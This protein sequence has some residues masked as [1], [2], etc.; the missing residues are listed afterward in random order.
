MRRELIAA[1]TFALASRI[2]AATARRPSS[3]SWS[4]ID[5]PWSR[6]RRSS[7]RSAD[8]DVTVR[9]ESRW[10]SACAR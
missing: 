4:T 3:S 8:V 6:T 5:Q 7:V 10:S 9:G 2:G 1:T